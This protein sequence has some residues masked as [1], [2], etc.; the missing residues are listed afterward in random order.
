MSTLHFRGRYRLPPNAVSQPASQI[1]GPKRNSGSRSGAG[2]CSQ[3]LLLRLGSLQFPRFQ[4]HANSLPPLPQVFPWVRF[5]F[6]TI[7]F[8]CFQ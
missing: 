4:L 2:N 7:D 5:S 3:A 8:F 1:R 6:V